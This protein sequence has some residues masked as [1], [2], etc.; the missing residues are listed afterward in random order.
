MGIEIQIP[1]IGDFKDIP[2]IEIH[3]KEG[4]TIGPDDPLVS[5]ESDKATMDVPS[6]SAGVVETI[7]VKLGDKVS[8]GSPLLVFKGEACQGAVKAAPRRPPTRPRAPTAPP[9]SPSRS[10]PR[11]PTPAPSGPRRARP[12]PATFPTSR[13]SMPAP[14]CGAWPASSA[15]T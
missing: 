15:S 10:R 3:V 13:R 6:P 7:L 2:I 14:A 12:A 1:D 11:A 9:C 4:D 5:L 8:E